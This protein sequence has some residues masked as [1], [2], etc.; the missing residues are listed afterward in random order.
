[1]M[2]FPFVVV[3]LEEEQEN[4]PSSEHEEEEGDY[5]TF[6]PFYLFFLNL[7]VILITRNLLKFLDF[8]LEYI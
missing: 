8:F 5:P 6:S 2:F 3:S 4:P 7:T 1:M